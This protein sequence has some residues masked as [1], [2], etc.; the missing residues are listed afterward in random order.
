M[1]IVTSTVEF[2]T[3][4]DKWKLEEFMTRKNTSS[5]VFNNRCF[6]NRNLGIVS[7]D[8]NFSFL[9]LFYFTYILGIFAFINWRKYW[10]LL[11]SFIH[12]YNV[13]WIYLLITLYCFSFL[14]LLFY[15]TIFVDGFLFYHSLS[16]P[17]L[18]FFLLHF[19]FF[20]KI[21]ILFKGKCV[22]FL[23]LAYFT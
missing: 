12:G 2:W 19:F 8:K 5:K 13:L 14:S 10:D 16:F 9:P 21:N 6:Y 4:F 1:V 11:W 20:L 17:I 22:V 18:F 23:R 7:I 3:I 15:A